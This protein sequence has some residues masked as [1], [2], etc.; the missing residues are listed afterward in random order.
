MG[1]QLKRMPRG[2]ESY[3]DSPIAEY[4]KFKNMYLELHIS[5]QEILTSDD[6]VQETVEKFLLMKEFNHLLN[7]ALKNFHFPERK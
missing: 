1:K 5:D 3:A 6:F 2:Y 4:L 7:A